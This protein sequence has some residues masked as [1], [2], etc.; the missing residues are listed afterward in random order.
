MDDDSDSTFCSWTGLA[1][2][3]VDVNMIAARACGSVAVIVSLC[4]W[5][6][7][8]CGLFCGCYKK[9]CF[10]IT[11]GILSVVCS[12]LS[13]F[14]FMSLSYKG[15]CVGNTSSCSISSGGVYNIIGMVFFI[16][17]GFMFCCIPNPTDEESAVAE[18]SAGVAAQ[19]AATGG[20]TIEET[21]ES[22]P[23]PEIPVTVN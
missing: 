8:L 11:F 5:T 3:W 1:E 18:P 17:A 10:R 6:T 13:G 12:A 16:L 4:L 9:R 14:M 15:R 21:T 2:W 20:K 23:E 7:L 19:S 22:P